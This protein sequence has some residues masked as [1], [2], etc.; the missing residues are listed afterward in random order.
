[1]IYADIGRVIRE[2]GCDPTRGRAH[3]SKARKVWLLLR[4]W[5][6]RTPS[7][8]DKHTS[9]PVIDACAFLVDALET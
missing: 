6:R 8:L 7:S 2:Q 9:A 5:I 4:A 1:L 3:T